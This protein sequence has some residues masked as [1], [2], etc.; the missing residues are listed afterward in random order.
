MLGN[1]GEAMEYLEKAI[2]IN[3][4]SDAAA[5]EISRIALAGGDLENAY[6]YGRMALSIDGYNE[7]YLNNM[8]NI[9]I[10][11]NRP[12]SLISILE[13]Y[14]ER[15][16]GND[17]ILYNLGGLYLEYGKPVEAE[18]IFTQ[19]RETYGDSQQ[20]IFA[21]LNAKNAQGK[22]DETEI[23]LKEMISR[24]PGNI[25]YLG[26]LAEQYRKTGEKEKADEIYEKLFEISPG[27]KLLQLSY[28][29]FLLEDKRF[30]ELSGQLNNLM[31]S[32][33][34]GIEEKIAIL[35]NVS[36]NQGFGS[37]YGKQLQVS[38]LILE[39]S[40]PGNFEVRMA[41]AGVFGA[42]GE[43]EEEIKRMSAALNDNHD[44]YQGWE[45]LLLKLNDYG[46]FDRLYSTAQKVA[47]D[48]NRYPLPK[49]LL[50]FA[51]TEKGD[52]EK[53]LEELNKVKILVNNQEE[54]MVQIYSL[55]ADIYYR[56]GQYEIAFGKFD[57]ALAINPDDVMLLNNYA[58]FLSEQNMNLPKAEE[59]I[60]RCLKSERN[61]TYLDTY[62]W[63]LYKQGKYRKAGEI[64]KEIF[65]EEE[66]DP[67]LLE[68][69]GYIRKALRDCKGAVVYWEMALKGDETKK[70]LEK[71]IELCRGK[72]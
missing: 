31:L 43:R 23:L 7:W 14:V 41:V 46:D 57:Q 15:I 33:S 1:V 65:K 54:Y 8:A 18:K 12:D 25:N 4:A 30:A 50:A 59:M 27:N 51:A 35:E 3:P 61:N 69:Y 26:M 71:E 34:L 70:Y 48:F 38:A 5:F 58:Y 47:T 36:G 6:R 17:E 45:E 20:L 13:T 53:A 63:V 67:E 52:Y 62:A 9:F 40:Y 39:A 66:N 11:A 28:V 42:T 68:H 60:V 22:S 29:D 21:L 10:S 16:P 49:L 72:M 55:E 56:Q 2:K 19:L 44:Y 37:E 32:D 64:M 24:E